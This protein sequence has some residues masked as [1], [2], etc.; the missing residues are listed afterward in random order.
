VH[1]QARWFPVLSTAMSI[2]ILACDTSVPRSSA[3]VAPPGAMATFTATT[4]SSQTP[5]P[6]PPSTTAPAE[7]PTL[8]PTRHVIA[9]LT[10]CTGRPASPDRGSSVERGSTWSGYVAAQPPASSSC[11]EASWVEPEITCGAGDSSVG[12]WVGIGG[13][14]S[15]DL[16]IF[17]DGRALER[18]GTGVDCE[19]GSAKQ[20][21][22][23]QAE[24]HDASDQP[25]S[26]ADPTQHGDMV[27]G[28]GD[29]I[30]A[31]VRYEDGTYHMTVANL[32]T[33]EARSSSQASTGNRRSS[34]EWVVSGEEGEALAR[35]SVV[36]FT[37]GL[38]TMAGEA[39]AIGSASWRRNEVD[40]WSGGFRRLR[41]SALSADNASFRVTWLHR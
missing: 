12:I 33:E 39:G 27:I 16:G 37:G 15:V 5:S 35:F 26:P 19:S 11:V 7:S 24:P 31:Q 36:T 1:P 32:S 34:A 40:E 9:A 25:F 2:L 22:W 6:T 41:V 21:A 28:A 17:D 18:A 29:R 10:H 13:Y 20:Y 38:S 14:T 23:H 4:A 3:T 8:S 30:W